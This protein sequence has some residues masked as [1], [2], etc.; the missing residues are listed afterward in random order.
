MEENKNN[1]ELEPERE[2]KIGGDAKIKLPVSEKL[3][4]FWYHYKWHTIAVA[5]ILV[6]AI[7]I[8][9]SLCSREKYDVYILYAGDVAISNSSQDGDIPHRMKVINS[10]KTVTSDFD[11]NGEISVA[12]KSIYA[13]DEEELARLQ[14]EGSDTSDNLRYNDNKTL[15]ELIAGSDYYL[16]FLDEAVFKRLAAETNMIGTVEPYL[17]GWSK[18]V[19]TCGSSS[20]IYLK[21]TGFRKFDGMQLSDDTVICIKLANAFASKSDK[22]MRERAIEVFKNIAAM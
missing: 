16:L 21:D 11:E 18:D 12:F 22:K 20:G 8:S 7:V 9:F 17:S 3:S 5:F 19:V 13:P 15:S 10:L 4:N 2:E 14:K 6:V 1:E